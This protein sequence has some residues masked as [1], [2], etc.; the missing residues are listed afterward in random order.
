M[1]SSGNT[2]AF[3]TC[4]E[5]WIPGTPPLQVEGPTV[6]G[7]GERKALVFPEMNELYYRPSKEAAEKTLSKMGWFAQ[8]PITDVDRVVAYVGRKHNGIVQTLIDSDIS[9]ERIIYAMCSCYDEFS[10]EKILHEQSKQPAIWTYVDCLH[11]KTSTFEYLIHHYL[12]TGN[13]FFPKYNLRVS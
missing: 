6:V 7:Q 12:N 9:E 2:V 10:V 5:I 3:I 11:P 1:S 8:R 4:H 13:L